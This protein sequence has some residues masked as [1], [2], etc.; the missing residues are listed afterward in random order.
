MGWPPEKQPLDT[1]SG[2]TGA[3]LPPGRRGTLGKHAGAC[4]KPSNPEPA[5]PDQGRA[6]VRSPSPRPGRS[7]KRTCT[8]TAGK[9]PPAMPPTPL[10]PPRRPAQAARHHDTGT[11]HNPGAPATLR[12]APETPTMRR[13]LT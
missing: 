5:M 11:E 2:H 12:L 7:L 8:G 9:A 13:R 4:S 10:T 6:W 3:A 1:R